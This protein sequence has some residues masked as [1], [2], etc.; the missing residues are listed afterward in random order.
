MSPNYLSL[1]FAND[2]DGTGQLSARAEASG[3]G[4][5]SA[6][7]FNIEDLEKFAR[8]IATYPPEGTFE[9]SSGFG[10][11]GSNELDQEHLAIRVYPLDGRGHIGVQVRMATPI[12]PDIRPQSQMTAKLEILT[13]YEPLRKFSADLMSL[14]HGVTTE[15]LLEG[16]SS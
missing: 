7:Y 6:A 8:S 1:R 16:D 3:F 2:G 5:Q 10:K 9:V 11:T 14:L 15:A 13:S 12:W 4:G